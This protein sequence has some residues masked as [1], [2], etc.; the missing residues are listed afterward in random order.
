MFRGWKQGLVSKRTHDH[1]NVWEFTLSNFHAK[2]CL[3]PHLI[4]TIIGVDMSIMLHL[5]DQDISFV[6]QTY[7]LKFRASILDAE[8]LRFPFYYYV[9]TVWLLHTYSSTLPFIDFHLYNQFPPL[10]A[11]YMTQS[12]HRVTSL[13]QQR[14][15]RLISQDILWKVFSFHL[16]FWN[17]HIWGPK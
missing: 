13:T 9:I 3:L 11:F 14:K 15:C 16:Y 17:T 7:V 6:K 5:F 8:N 2:D 1:V 10:L 4:L 12:Y